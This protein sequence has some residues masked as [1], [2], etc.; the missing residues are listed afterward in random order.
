M[1][2]D[3]ET[4]IAIE[5]HL[6]GIKFSDEFQ[7]YEHFTHQAWFKNNMHQWL[8]L[9][10]ALKY[11]QEE[12][13]A[14]GYSA[15]FRLRTDIAFANQM[16]ILRHIEQ[17]FSGRVKPKTCIA[18]SDL[19]FAFS[20]QDIDIFSAFF[21]QI[22]SFYLSKDWIDFPYKPLNPEIVL[23]SKGGTRIEWNFF[24]IS[25]IGANPSY[26]QFFESFAMN[27]SLINR[28]FLDSCSGLPGN[29]EAFDY[30][31]YSAVRIQNPDGFSSEK[32]F[33]HY[34]ASCGIAASHHG[35]LFTGPL[36]RNW[37]KLKLRL[38]I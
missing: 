3:P 18:R 37:S 24:P 17:G 25:Y 31:K 9:K 19:L 8:K 27:F 32:C 6:S 2:I 4:R 12:W 5:R 22:Q 23:A 29:S 20:I 35:D 21:D 30:R 16:Q 14:R 36:I 33:A 26:D 15:I 34:L 7:E 38:S 1:Q 13:N 28:D 10:L 11:W